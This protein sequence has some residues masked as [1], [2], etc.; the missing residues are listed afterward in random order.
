MF[1]LIKH[2]RR[3]VE[4]RLNDNDHRMIK[5]GDLIIIVNNTTKEELVCKVVGVLRYK[6][7]DELF[8]VFPPEYFGVQNLGDIQKMV[9]AWYTPQ[10]EAQYGV[11][12]IKLHVLK[13]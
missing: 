12:G 5:I 2:G 9:R 6:K 7:F 8:T 4:P 1:D 13:A 10:A 11:L 3:L